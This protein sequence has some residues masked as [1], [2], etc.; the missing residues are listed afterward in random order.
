METVLS[1]RRLA[2]DT[3][4][5]Q[6]GR[7][8]QIAFSIIT[9]VILARR[10]GVSEFGVFSTVVAVQ[11][12][13]FAMADL[14]LG[15]L[16]LRAVAQRNGEETLAIRRSVRWLYLSSSTVLAVS[17][18]IS[19]PLVGGPLH[20]LVPSVLIG[21]SYIY[22]PARIGLERGYW[23]G[24]LQFGRATLVD[25][26]AAGLR[27]TGI[28]LVAVLGG[29]TLLS[30][31]AG[32]AVS[33][34]LTI[35][36][37]HTWLSYPAPESSRTGRS[38][39]WRLLHEAAPFALSSLTWNTFTELPKILLAPVAGAAAVGLYAAGARVLTTALVPLQSLLLVITPRLFAFAGERRGSAEQPRLLG[40]PLP[41]AVGLGTL[42]ASVLTIL[43]A[44]MAPILPL[45]LGAEYRPAVPILRILAL[46][47]PF[48]AL[49]SVSGDWLGGVGQQ[50][51]RFLLTLA[52]ALL[53]LP[54]LWLA[55]RAGG[56]TGAAIAYSSLTAWLALIT[57]IAT[58]R[59]LQ[60]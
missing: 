4:I 32:I 20:R 39:P 2:A 45:I 22:A 3:V 23:L 13:C 12:A 43:V 40:H 27:T 26:C 50:R 10:L 33:G 1:R 41:K 11:S 59:H 49:A 48:L 17:C 9:F 29:V 36:A 6:T 37:V 58:R 24:A 15:Q 51:L 42:A 34:V 54:T 31:A 38:S 21:L 52:T 47:L 25:V 30:F 14:G 5:T 8:L 19:L 28:A 53:A 60:P 44:G 16:A 18:F 46:S 57:A 35:W 7:V 56:A 55:S